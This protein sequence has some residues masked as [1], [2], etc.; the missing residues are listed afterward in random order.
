[1]RKGRLAVAGVAALSILG[2][3]TASGV[4][5][6]GEQGPPPDT[7]PAQPV[8]VV[9][10]TTAP[11]PVA[12]QGTAAIQGSV[13][14]VQSGAW[15]VG[16]T[17]TPEV[18]LAGTPTV[19]IEPGATTVI[20]AQRFAVS[21]GSVGIVTIDVSKLSSMRVSATCSRSTGSVSNTECAKLQMSLYDLAC[22]CQLDKFAFP[23]FDVS[24]EYDTPG[25]SLTIGAQN[26]NAAGSAPIDLTWRI[27][28]RA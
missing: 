1:M 17:G 16:I 20:S 6:A 19:A 9:N 14:A 22:S 23:D 25:T 12:V 10:D 15:S 27:F 8:Q 3:M 24:R 2:V 28:G 26:G 5:A 4:W 13:A 11:V 21:P 18:K 7:R